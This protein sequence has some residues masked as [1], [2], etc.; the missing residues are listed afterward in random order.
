MFS[1]QGQ[2]SYALKSLNKFIEDAVAALSSDREKIKEHIGNK[3]AFRKIALIRNENV[4]YCQ[5]E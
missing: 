4:S 1:H 5:N 3:Y 2:Q